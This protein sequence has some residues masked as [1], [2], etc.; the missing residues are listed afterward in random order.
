[1]CGT[2]H[3]RRKTTICKDCEKKLEED[4][5]KCILCREVHRLK[6]KICKECNSRTKKFSVHE[7]IRIKDLHPI[8]QKNKITWYELFTKYK[9]YYET[10]MEEWRSK[11]Y[12][13]NNDII[14]NTYFNVY[15]KIKLIY[16]KL[17]KLNYI[18]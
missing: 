10:W 3:H 13:K 1:M 4:R 5:K 7:I 14:N 12:N 2:T 17:T 9:N 18:N 8:H 16:E 15:R 6:D 11:T